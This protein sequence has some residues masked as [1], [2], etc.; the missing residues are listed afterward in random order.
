MM[1]EYIS[2]EM[3]NENVYYF[4]F[5]YAYTCKTITLHF[6]PNITM[7]EFIAEVKQKVCNENIEIV[8][9]GQYIDE[10]RP[11][12][13]RHIVGSDNSLKI[14]YG[15]HWKNVAFYIRKSV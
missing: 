1:S 12:D 2:I 7:S 14:I 6:D 9:A 10:V 3:M 13:A 4:T 15:S 5:K 8:K 11:E